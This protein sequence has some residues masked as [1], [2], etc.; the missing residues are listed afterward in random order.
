M[1][2]SANTV[3][4]YLAELP[5]DRRETVAAVREVVLANLPEGYEEGMD[6]GMI[7]W[8]VPL[9]RYPDTYNGHPLG[10]VALASQK[11]YLSL[12]LMGAYADGDDF[13]ARYEATGK[14]LNMGKSCV[15]FKKLADLPLELIGEVVAE[16]T[17]EQYIEIY[18]K[19]RGLR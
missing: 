2:S 8:H 17:P 10:Y 16:V 3:E 5:P 7:C 14:K 6:F 12:Y 18:E 11:Q 19:A 9:S 13:R 4:D 1:Q 15:R